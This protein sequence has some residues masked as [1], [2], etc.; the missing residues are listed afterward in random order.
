MYSVTQAQELILSSVQPLGAER[1]GILEALGRVLAEVVMARRDHPPWDNSAMDG[2]AVRWED[3]RSAPKESPVTLRLVE[4][5]PAGEAA[6]RPVGPGEAILI[7]TGAPIPS[8]ADTVVRIEGTRRTGSEVQILAP[9]SRGEDIRLRGENIREGEAVL[10][11]GMELRAAQIGMLATVGRSMV[12]VFRRPRVAILVTGD[13][14]A[15]LDEPLDAQKIYNSNSYAVFAQVREAGGI[16]LLLGI[17]RDHPEALKE[18]LSEAVSSDLL[19][20]SGGVSVGDYDYVKPVLKELGAEI[21]FWRVRMRPGHPV[22]FGLLRGQPFLG[23]PGNP[24]STMVAFEEF[25]RPML[26]RLAGYPTYFLPVMEAALQEPLTNKPG[27]THFVR[28]ILTQEGAAAMVR[29]TGPQGSGILKSMTQ[30]NAL[31][32]LDEKTEKV[33]A[34]EKVKVQLLGGGLPYRENPGF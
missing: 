23:L 9:V 26:R 3:I 33:E 12:R 22:V 7:M 29:S 13:E 31:I 19:L 24:V 11:Q 14:L 17:A 2:V 30:A 28:G 1:V 32:V 16:P 27:R 5:V 25:A 8:G 10:T 34:G 20:I 18:K 4:K 15:D 6:T 21:K